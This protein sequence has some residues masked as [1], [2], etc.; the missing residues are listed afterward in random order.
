MDESGRL[1]TRGLYLEW[2]EVA[3]DSAVFGFPVLQIS[4]LQ[5]HSEGGGADFGK[6]EEIRDKA[7]AGIVS[8]RLNHN[9]L[10]ESMM[11]ED[12]GFRFVEM[13]YQPQL[14]DLSR[15]PEPVHGFL[16]ARPGST[17][18][19]PAVLEIAGTAFSNERFHAD[20]RLPSEYGDKRY[21]NWVRS[22]VGH[23]RQRLTVLL[24][25]KRLVSFFVTEMLPD[26]TDYWHLNAV[27]P[28]EQGRGYG[29]RAWMTM[30]RQAKEKGAK[31]VRTCVAAR[32]HRVINL[33]ARLGFLFPPPMMTFHWVR[34]RSR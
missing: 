29:R 20:P 31:R 23:P 30:V 14:D 4:Y 12:H 8:C 28:S 11:L 18:D 21:R 5:L 7:G 33:Y 22:S 26:G 6:F 10:V 19:L 16:A 2:N 24:D 34:A 3:W 15:S 25:G 13:V 9:A 17:G 32:N 27:S 1:D